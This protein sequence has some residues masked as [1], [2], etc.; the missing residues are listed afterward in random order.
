MSPNS[1]TYSPIDLGHNRNVSPISA[2]TPTRSNFH[3]VH[4]GFGRPGLKSKPAKLCG[5]P[6]QPDRVGMRERCDQAQMTLSELQRSRGVEPPENP[7]TEILEA[8]GYRQLMEL[9]MDIPSM[10]AKALNAVGKAMSFRIG[11]LGAEAAPVVSKKTSFSKKLSI[12]E[13]VKKHVKDFEIWLSPS[14]KDSEGLRGMLVVI[15]EIHHDISIQTIIK[16]VML[17]FSRTQGD[18]L[19]TEGGDEVLCQ[20]RE[21]ELKM[22]FGDCRILEKDSTAYG[23]LIKL[24]EE[25]DLRLIDCVS[26]IKEHIPSAQQDFEVESTFHYIDFIKRYASQ[27]SSHAMPGF[28][29][30]YAK[31]EAADIRATKEGERLMD[32]RNLDMVNRMLNN[33]T[34]VGVNYLIVGADHLKGMREQVKHRRCIF[35][36]PRSIVEHNPSK[37]IIVDFKSEL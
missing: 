23:Y 14:A 7:H 22:E 32:E 6:D 29:P 36:L 34:E 33:L 19:F 30:L 1:T 31:A 37:S 8:Y 10:G 26:Y 28:Y 12:D 24:V 25:L 20:Q 3:L 13:F 4:L 9:V 18:R 2:P 15:G 27:L 16:K 35:M 11:P 21:K 17:G 5:F